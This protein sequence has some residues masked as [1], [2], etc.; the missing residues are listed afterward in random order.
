MLFPIQ[1][2]KQY[3]HRP[4]QTFSHRCLVCQSI[5]P[6]FVHSVSRYSTGSSFCL[7]AF[8]SLVYVFLFF[9]SFF[10]RNDTLLLSLVVN[11]KFIILD[12]IENSNRNRI[13][14]QTRIS[15]IHATIL[16]IKARAEHMVAF[17]FIVIVIV[18]NAY[19]DWLIGQIISLFK[20]SWYNKPIRT[21]ACTPKF[22]SQKCEPNAK[23]TKI[24]D[25]RAELSFSALSWLCT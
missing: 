6:V 10:M 19:Y 4:C 1:L 8:W 5:F 23:Q 9:C 3:S 13:K 2:A 25:P 24:E 20:T 18:R 7:S 12:S 11:W 21:H 16:W 14:N 22:T 15:Q 17:V